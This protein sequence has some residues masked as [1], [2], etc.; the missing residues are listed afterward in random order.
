MTRQNGPGAD[1][2]LHGL[3]QSWRVDAS[4]PPRF[5]EEVWRR[6]GRAEEKQRSVWR[7]LAEWLE[8]FSRRPAWAGVY[9][10]TLLALGVWAGLASADHYGE[11]VERSWQ[12]AY[13]QS[14]S[15]LL[16]AGLK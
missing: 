10:A 6:I 2:D 11:Q 3:L 13:V 15:P 7:G 5:K 16:Q 4:L 8:V 1:E 14:V 9:V 12:A